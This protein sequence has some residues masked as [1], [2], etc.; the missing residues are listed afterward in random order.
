[1]DADVLIF[2]IIEHPAGVDNVELIAREGG[3]TGSCSA[4]SIWR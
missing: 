1:M 2:G 3:L 4:L